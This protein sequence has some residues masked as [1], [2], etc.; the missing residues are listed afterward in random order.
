[1]QRML[2]CAAVVLFL[3]ILPAVL[4]AQKNEQLV[5]VAKLDS[6]IIVDLK[7]ATTDNFVGEKLYT[8]ARCFLR[9]SVARRLIRVQ[10]RLREMGMGLKI[11]DGYR[12]LSVQKRMWQIVSE[13][14]LVANPYRG[15]SYHNRGA[16]VDVT[17]VDSLGAELE[18]P[19]GYDDFSYKA[20]RSYYGA[21]EEALKHREIL[22]QAMTSEGFTPI[23]SEWWHFNAPNARQYP[24]LDIPINMLLRNRMAQSE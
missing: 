2:H 20:R 19:T 16:A 13:P 23:Q 8:E 4:F 18:M 3:L 11:W 9:A 1:M 6:T 22:L 10:Q 24:V 21:S 7:Y 14:G 12:P 17:L 15:G 5:E